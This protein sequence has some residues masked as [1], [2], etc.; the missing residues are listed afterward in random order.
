MKRLAVFVSGS[1]TNLENLAQ[2]IEERKLKGCKIVL[3]VS[4]DAEAYVLKRAKRLNLDFV[5][6]KRTDYK[7][8]ADFEG[9]IREHLQ[10]AG[11]DFVILAGFMRILSPAFVAAY[12]WR[13]I[14]IHPAYTPDGPVR[15]ALLTHTPILTIFLVRLPQDKL[16]VVIGEVIRPV[17]KTTHQ[18]A[19]HEYTQQWVA[20]CEKIIRQYPGQWGWNHNRWKTQKSDIH[21]LNELRKSKKAARVQ[22]V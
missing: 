21:N 11:I 19:L 8:K 18:A 16:K 2:K 6:V 13:I 20:S 9:K 7:T 10:K 22:K 3:V 17:I 14:N 15:L 12:R 5:V 4:D 1:G